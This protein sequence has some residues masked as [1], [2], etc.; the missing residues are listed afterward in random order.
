MKKTITVIALLAMTFGAFAQNT[1]KDRLE[2]LENKTVEEKKS[3]SKK[4]EKE[5]QLFDFQILSHVGYGWHLMDAPEFQQGFKGFNREFFM[6]TFELDIWPTRWMSLNLGLDLKW[7]NFTPST[8]NIF[9]L[10]AKNDIVYDTMPA[11]TTGMQ[12][13]LHY[14]SLA[15]PLALN[16]N[17]GLIGFSAG[18]EF[19][20][21]PS[22]RVSIKDSYSIGSSEY[23]VVTRGCNFNKLSWD[24][25]AT[26]YAGLTGIYF[27]Y[28]PQQPL[29]PT[30][31]FGLMTVGIYFNLTGI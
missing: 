31:P 16:L 15:A 8:G 17:F 19:V 28:Y 6:N 20:Y 10:D 14:F 2:E 21:T 5:Y 27:R 13:T 26:V 3:T 12:S 29:I 25:F 1:G 22:S 23:N 7:Q 11:G 4:A 24:I 18:A 30:A 9:R